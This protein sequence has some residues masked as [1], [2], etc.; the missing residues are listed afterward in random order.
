[1]ST[2][3]TALAEISGG[4]WLYLRLTETSNSS[5][6]FTWSKAHAIQHVLGSPYPILDLGIS[7]DLT[8]SYECAFRTEAE[9]KRFEEMTGKPIILKSRAGNAVTG[10]ITAFSKRVKT[11][12]IAYSFSL[13]KITWKELG[14]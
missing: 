14:P 1:M 11:F 6:S 9:A 4:E 12:Y 2:E 10:A 5:Q 8:G 3:T 13:Q 7:E